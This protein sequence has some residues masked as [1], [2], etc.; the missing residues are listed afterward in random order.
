MPD[1][2]DNSIPSNANLPKPDGL[3]VKSEGGNPQRV[4]NPV[5]PKPGFEKKPVAG[6]HSPEPGNTKPEGGRPDI[7]PPVKPVGPKP[8]LEE[9]AVAG[10]PESAETDSKSEEPLF[11][12]NAEEGHS[13]SADTKKNEEENLSENIQL[14]NDTPS[15]PSDNIAAGIE[16]LGNEEAPPENRQEKP[17]QP[18]TAP[19]KDEPVFTADV[20]PRVLFKASIPQ[21]GL[22]DWS[23]QYFWAVDIGTHTIKVIGLK[24]KKKGL[25]LIYLSLVEIIPGYK[26]PQQEKSYRKAIVS[27]LDMAV[28][29]IKQRQKE[30]FISSIGANLSVVRQVQYP[31]A[32]KDKLLAAIQWEVRKFI[33]YEPD[34]VVVDAQI[35]VSGE[36][37]MDVL[38]AAVPKEHL[39]S[40]QE[41]L[42]GV[43]LTS[44]TVDTDSIAL[45]NALMT[46]VDL[47]EKET[48]LLIDIGA[49][50]TILNMFQMGG[51]F[52]TRPLS[53]AGDRFTQD[54]SLHLK[55][56]FSEAECVKRGERIEGVKMTP[57][58]LSQVLT[59]SYKQLYSEIQKSI[60]FYSKQ[61]GIKD[62][63]YLFLSGGG[64]NLPGLKEFLSKRLGKN[65]ALLSPITGL[66]VNEKNIN[67]EELIQFGPQIALVLGLA[68]RMNQI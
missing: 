64:A 18:Y 39:K 54:I 68:L 28:N 52:F 29:G 21:K 49:K 4:V 13:E 35:L 43:G 19:P 22:L 46:Q 62:F 24:R 17:P 37:K 26:L 27:A 63:H 65:I 3:T 50:T 56:D 25:E 5:G 31:L 48:A 15:E 10:V 30:G 20:Q 67:K 38:L 1:T 60:I 55:K 14:S 16:R 47:Q 2:K 51:L 66:E 8:G 40:H 41:I 44:T 33:P 45:T 12:S 36:K 7:Q 57:E 59:P 23:K 42:T 53:I 58:E 9:K 61:T 32:V 11:V 34:E 6:E